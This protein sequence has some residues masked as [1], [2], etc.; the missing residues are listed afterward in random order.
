MYFEKL[1]LSNVN[2]H[3]VFFCIMT[4]C[5]LHYNTMYSVSGH[6]YLRGTYSLHLR[7]ILTLKTEA[8][9]SSETSVPTY[10]P[11]FYHNPKT[12]IW[13]FIVVGNLNLANF[14]FIN[15][16]STYTYVRTLKN[17]CKISLSKLKN[18]SVIKLPPCSW[19]VISWSL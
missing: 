19:C 14:S 12:K 6:K 13:I 10:K 1:H 11:T 3:V 2:T 7:V 17:P 4:P 16:T 5:I 9:C 15:S 8:I 18:L